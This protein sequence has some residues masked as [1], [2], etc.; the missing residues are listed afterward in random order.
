MGFR[1]SASD[2]KKLI[3]SLKIDCRLPSL[4]EMQSF[5]QTRVSRPAFRSLIFS[6]VCITRLSSHPRV[7]G[8]ACPLPFS[9]WL[10]RS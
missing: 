8:V 1:F 3:F 2:F 4:L 10:G 6:L 5:H 7:K 9:I